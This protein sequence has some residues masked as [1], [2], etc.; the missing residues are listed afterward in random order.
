MKNELPSVR[1][2][3]EGVEGLLKGDHPNVPSL[4]R[5]I[6]KEIESRKTTPSNVIPF[7]KSPDEIT[8]QPT[9]PA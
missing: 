9:K 8:G 5:R 4:L 1:L 6:A 2:I 3:Y 7:P